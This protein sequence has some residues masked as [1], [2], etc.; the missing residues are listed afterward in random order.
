[1]TSAEP[2]STCLLPPVRLLVRAPSPPVARP[3]RWRQK[4]PSP[5]RSAVNGSLAWR[6]TRMIALQ[7]DFCH[8][9]S[10]N[11]P[12]IRSLRTPIQAQG[13]GKPCAPH[14]AE[15]FRRFV[16][17]LACTRKA[18]SCSSGMAGSE[19]C[20]SAIVPA[21]RS[22]GNMTVAPV[23]PAVRPRAPVGGFQS[24]AAHAT[25]DHGVTIR[26]VRNSPARRSPD[27]QGDSRRE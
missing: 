19:P 18:I 24:R 13:A 21:S 27:M 9:K 26:L 22:A 12:R 3:R 10:S 6:C 5:K 15:L 20:C 25:R 14:S 23:E 7:Q 1:M 16:S 11:T 2:A 8:R 4:F 17:V